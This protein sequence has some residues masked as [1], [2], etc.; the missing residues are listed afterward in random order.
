MGGMPLALAA[1]AELQRRRNDDD[2][3]V[4]LPRW[5]WQVEENS[6]PTW[7]G[8]SPVADLHRK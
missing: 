3:A 4:T 1:A 7:G 6:L 5:L 8:I 2:E